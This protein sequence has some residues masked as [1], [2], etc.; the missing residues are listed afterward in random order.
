MSD[1]SYMIEHMFERESRILCSNRC[2][3]TDRGRGACEAKQ[4]ATQH[5]SIEVTVSRKVGLSRMTSKEVRDA[6]HGLIELTPR[7]WRVVDSPG[8]QRLRGI[9]QLAMTHLV[10]PGARHTR[11]EHCMG[12]C[13]VAGELARKLKLA[14]IGRI[15]A[16]AL[17][18]DIGH[19]PFSHVSEFVFEDLT[20]EQH[21]HEKISAAIVRHHEPV[22]KALGED[23]EWVADLLAGTGHG[24]NRT[25]ER[26]II[27]GPADIDKLDYL[28]RDSHYCG[29]AYGRYDLDK[30]IESAR[31]VTKPEGDYLAYHSDGIY[32]LEGMLLARYHMHRQVYG[33]KTRVA[34]DRMLVR[35]M[36][37]GVTEGVLPLTVFGPAERG[38]DFVEE[39]LR[40]D[41]RR[42]ID[43]LCGAD[44]SDGG[45]I[46]RA[47]RERRLLRR[48]AR[49]TFNDL[50]DHRRFGKDRLLIGNALA[51]K[52]DVL[53]VHQESAEKVVAEAAGV[54]PI[55][56]VLYWEELQSPISSR[57]SFRVTDKEV[58]IT[59]D[60]GKMLERFNEV[61]EIFHSSVAPARRTVDVYVRVPDGVDKFDRS[62][63]KKIRSAAMDALCAIG[64]AGQAV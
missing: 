19:G 50:Y 54:E 58:L 40:W 35:A 39:Y 21:V 30:L 15:R 12:A 22:R 29:V 59:D 45:A 24:K 4:S 11:F 16:A 2:V 3:G 27:A 8:F 44:G 5:P 10:Y 37:L 36:S 38:A 7:E 53:K 18:H 52:A 57:E 34:T 60:G 9:Q 26:D 61:S 14:T 42:V 31:L 1:A 48:V 20:G 17:V 41:D 64:Q 6:V 47:L 49:I 63:E 43:A 33:H 46:M 55:W 51:P 25:A 13:H 23:A 32:A 56:T 28:L 62:T